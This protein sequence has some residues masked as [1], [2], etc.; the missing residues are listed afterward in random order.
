MAA[1][2]QSSDGRFAGLELNI[3]RVKKDG[4]SL[5]LL[6]CCAD[7]EEKWC[8]VLFSKG[9]ME[10]SMTSWGFCSSRA[11]GWAVNTLLPSTFTTPGMG[12]LVQGWLEGHSWAPVFHGT[13]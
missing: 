4:I 9:G 2:T 7:D 8:I 12:G 13:I 10:R 11:E 6:S 1:Q 3:T 5:W